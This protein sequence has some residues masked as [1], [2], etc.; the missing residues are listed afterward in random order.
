VIS[1]DLLAVGLGPQAATDA[2]IDPSAS[3]A[4]LGV[5]L[6]SA[7]QQ[8]ATDRLSPRAVVVDLGGL[9]AFDGGAGFL[10][11]L[12]AAAN[13]QLE[14]GL[15]EL[16]LANLELQPAVQFLAEMAPAASFSAAVPSSDASVQLLGLRG[17]TS[18]RGRQQGL[19]PAL[20]LH[21]DSSLENLAQSSNTAGVP[22]DPALVKVPG[23]GAAG[24]TGWAVLALGGA[25][26]TG[27]SWLA[28]QTQLAST[29]RAAD[30]ALVVVDR[31]D[32]ATRGGGVVATVSEAAQA[33]GRPC[34]VLSQEV[35]IGVREM[36][37][38]G[39]EAAY[40]VTSGAQL[41]A[42]LRLESSRIARSWRW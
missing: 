20:M 31:F 35:S 3:S 18:L 33:A 2:L 13:V 11:A 21:L 42:R 32:F 26:A 38:F 1:R 5:A 9:P 10:S 28:E 19:D 23:A 30:L 16:A 37:T 25:I 7:L 22:T 34:I 17:V 4:P 24:G 8:A 14:A 27:S 36:R 40:Q 29:V 12:G 15:P 41:A 39:V 6:R